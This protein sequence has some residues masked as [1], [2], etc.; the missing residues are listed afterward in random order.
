MEKFITKHPNIFRHLVIMKVIYSIISILILIGVLIC[1]PTVV[2][3]TIVNQ[4]QEANER[5]VEFEEHH[6]E[7][8]AQQ[9]QMQTR[10]ESKMA[11][12]Q[13]FS[14]HVAE[15]QSRMESEAGQMNSDFQE[16]YDAVYSAVFGTTE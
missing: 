8:Q 16:Q 15:M 11:E 13:D 12:A 3:P 6:A 5:L 10:Y 2:V 14:A 1:I 7:V 4:H 9:E